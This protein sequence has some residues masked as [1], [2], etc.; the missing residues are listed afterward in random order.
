MGRRGPAPAPIEVKKARGERRPSRV[1]YEAPK[2]DPPKSTDVP[3]GLTGAGKA[4]WE[5]HIGSLVKAGVITDPDLSA[6]EDYCR[7]LTDLRKFEAAAKKAGPELAIAKGYQGMVVKLRQ[8][9][10]QLRQQIGLTP[11][12]RGSIKAQGEKAPETDDD[13]FFGGPQGVVRGGKA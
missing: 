13:R 7:A 8:Q 6:F 4:E 11:S 1:N 2:L 3:S 5:R 10:S 9:C 12:S